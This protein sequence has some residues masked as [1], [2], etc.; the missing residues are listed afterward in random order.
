MV[1]VERKEYLRNYQRTWY[2]KRR[3]DYFA[4][5]FCFMCGG[6]ERLELDH[7]DPAHKIANS[8]W[9]WSKARRQAEIVKCDPL[10]YT[11]HKLKTLLMDKKLSEHGTLAG[12]NSGCRCLDCTKANAIR[13]ALQRTKQ[14]QL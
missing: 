3:A 10:C 1:T 6:T 5:K 9:S 14:K 12:Y 2:A 13:R 8:I 4:D 7:R 11:C